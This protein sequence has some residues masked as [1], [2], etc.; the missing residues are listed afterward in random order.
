[1]KLIAR[2][3]TIPAILARARSNGTIACRL[4]PRSMQSSASASDR[5]VRG[6]NSV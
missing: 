2:G 1:M 6:R 5:C 3:R 4:Q